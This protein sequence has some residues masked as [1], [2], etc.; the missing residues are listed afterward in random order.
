MAAN[1]FRT[2]SG[3]QIDRS[4][5][6]A[7]RFAGRSY[8]GYAGDTL[9]S[10][11]LANGVRL[12]AR[13]FKYHRPRGVLSIG[14]EE[15]NAL[16]TL[17]SGARREPNSR[18]TMVELYDFLEA[19]AQHA[20]PSLGFDIGAM[21]GWFAPLL[22]AGFY[23]KT[24]MGPLRFSWMWYE[25]AIRKAAGLGAA[26]REPD[27]DVYEKMHGFADVVIVGGGPAG[28]SAALAAAETGG[29]VILIDEAPRLGGWLLREQDSI[30]GAPGEEWAAEAVARLAA[31]PNVTLLTRTTAFGVFDGGTVGAV[32]RVSDH[33]R[34]PRPNH[35]HSVIASRRRSNPPASAVAAG[36]LLRRE[37]P[38]N[39]ERLSFAIKAHDDEWGRDPATPRQRFWQ[40]RAR[41]IVVAAGSIEQPLVFGGND[42]PGVMLAGAVRGY[43]NQYGVICGRRLA[44]ATDNDSGY[45]TALDARTAHLGVEAIIDRRRDPAGPLVE[46]AR[47]AGIEIIAGGQIARTLYGRKLYGVEVVRRDAPPRI[48]NC[49]CLAMSGGWAPTIHLSSH[50]GG[51]P[52]FD[53]G[54]GLF[55]PCAAANMDFAG[56]CA[57][58]F[59]LDDCLKSGWEAGLRAAQG[60]DIPPRAVP[61]MTVRPQETA[62]PIR[63]GRKAFID[64]QNDVTTRDIKLAAWEG[65]VSVEHLKRYTTLGMGTDQGKTSNLAG[66][67]F[68]SRAREMPVASVGATTFRPPFT[69]VALGA[70]AGTERGQHFAPLRRTPM[71]SWHEAAGAVMG[72]AG[73]WRRPKAYLRAGEDVAS[74]GQREALAVRRCVGVVDVSTLGKIEVKGPDAAAFLDRIYCN[75]VASLKTGRARYGVM[76]RED[77]MVLD[78]GTI[79]RFG[80][81]HF[82]I[83]TTTAAAGKVMDHLE[84]YAQV[85]WPELR[86]RMTSVTDQ[87]GAIAVAGPQSRTLLERLGGDIDFSDKAFPY[88]AARIGLIGDL[89]ARLLRVSYSG[90]RAYEIHLPADDALACWEML[91]AKGADLGVMPYGTEAMGILRIEKG[92]V[93][94]AEIDGRTT[95][96]DLGLGRMARA[97]KDFV[98]KR[99]LERPALA[100][101]NRMALVGLIPADR[102]SRLRAGAQLTLDAAGAPPVPMVGHITSACFSPHMGHPIALA[103]VEGGGARA[104]ETLYARFPL[105][106]ETVAVKVV[107]PVF[108][109]PEGK[110]LHA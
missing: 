39:D 4:W 43:L 5:P 110:R 68:L 46:A 17:R 78:D 50:L 19:D 6:L 11:L 58:L 79:A 45:R 81:G 106:N 102:G 66:L 44:V 1:R 15:P 38:R 105:R 73:L 60:A 25:R 36:G 7:F 54:S 55:L 8:T 84:R 92:H 30:E 96:A 53:A 42:R 48:V 75:A 12:M 85:A 104:G 47:A 95:P 94:G 103:L 62:E 27:P 37:A 88:P 93:A 101:G 97:E 22:T 34:E 21:N 51:R 86:V 18:A 65:Y 41:R 87:F 82:Y 57:G 98:G 108:V 23:Y 14:S 9:A 67:D 59:A 29:R 83:T 26:S 13:S 31:M 90:E 76:L 24:F 74:A 99:L 16:V 89:P 107:S 61:V 20:W 40:I 52:A 33:L 63:K 72:E 28:L 69:P 91:L 109:D 100:G 49:D 35:P 10:A 77:G 71:Q 80:E 64:F 56:A 32:E 70:L 2:R 3:G